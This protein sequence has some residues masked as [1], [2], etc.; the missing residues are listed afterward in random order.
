MKAFKLVALGIVLFF[1]GATQAQV[2]VHFNIGSQPQW[3]PVGYENSRYYYL[4]DVEA[5]YDVR[6]SMFIY[7]EGNSWIH[8]SYLP[9]RYRN[10]DLYNGYKVAMRDYRGNT[11]YYNHREYRA[12]YANGRNRFVQR[13]IGERPGR[14]FFRDK[15]D[16]ERN[17]AN[18][19]RYNRIKGNDKAGDASYDKRGYERNQKN[20]NGRKNGN[21]KVNKRRDKGNKYRK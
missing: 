18:R 12:K 6:N 10:Y 21:S 20:N 17:Q 15:S 3:A 19:G 14:T 16:R 1:A 11:P 4:P 2:S 5:Y 8:R 7:Y 13:T 9:N